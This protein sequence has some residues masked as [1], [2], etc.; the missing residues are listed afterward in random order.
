MP[1]TDQ[2]GESN[3]VSAWPGHEFSW[4]VADGTSAAAGA[5]VGRAW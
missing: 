4:S 5:R 2:T 1:T 3:P